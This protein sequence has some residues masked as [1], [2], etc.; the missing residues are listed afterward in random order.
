MSDPSI[1]PKILYIV[2]TY[3][4]REGEMQNPWMIETVRHL[5]RDGYGLEILA[6]AYRGLTTHTIDGMTVHRYRYGR[7]DWEILTHD[8]GAPNKIRSNPLLKLVA[9]PY[10]LCGMWAAFRLVRRQ[11]YDIIHS[12]WPFPHGLMGWAAWLGSPRPKPK[13]VLQF[14]GAELLLARHNRIIR[15]LLDLLL[16][17]ADGV[18]CNSRFT[19]GLVRDIRPTP[20]DI[21]AFGSPLENDPQPLPDNSVKEI[22]TVGRIIE[23]KGLEY[24]LRALPRILSQV[25]VRLYV[26]GGGEKHLEERLRAMAREFGLEDAVVFTGKISE[27]DLKERYRRCD[28]YC[29]PAIIDS[30]GD[31]EGLGVVLLEALHYGRPV[32]ASNVGGIP[33]V[34]RDGETGLLT[35]DKDPNDLAEKLLAVL[36]NPALARKLAEGGAKHARETFG[37]DTILSHWNRFYSRMTSS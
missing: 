33:D 17:T 22:L 15:L 21:I 26:V 9:L 19:A 34:V 8:E 3:A 6:P 7:P 11:R 36:T 4:R 32:V 31:T 1:K 18:V 37:W 35:R 27:A 20:S 24:L 12:H 14:H 23:R 2:S 30:R 10:I 13:L 16:R 28:V 29:H 25:P 5:R